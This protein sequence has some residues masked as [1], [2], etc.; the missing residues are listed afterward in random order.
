M[1]YD[2][3]PGVFVARERERQRVLGAVLA[4]RGAAVVGPGGVGK[5]ALLAAVTARLGASRF[6]VVRTA[7]TE[8]GRRVPFGAFRALLGDG[9]GLDEGRAYGLLRGELARRAGRRVPVLVIDDA[10]YLDDASAALTLSLAA[11]GGPRLVVTARPGLPAPDAVVAL[12]KDGYPERLDLAPFGVADT[13]RLVRALLDG[14]AARPTVELL[15]RW[16]GG[17]PLLLTELVRHG[18]A[19]GHLVSGGGVW[20]RRG[21]LTAPPRLAELV[22][23]ELR[24]LDPRHRDALAAVALGEPLPLPVLEKVVPWKAI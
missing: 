23:R 4:R 11:E 21:P 1:P 2:L 12:W 24:G 16:T 15:H 8:A 3:V 20:W 22:E 6:A 13:A 10:H 18:H 14:A 19:T 17:N 7:A 9:G 5:T